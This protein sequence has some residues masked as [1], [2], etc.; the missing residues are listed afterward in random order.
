M[1]TGGTATAARFELR[2]GE[3]WRDPFP[4]YAAL[5][6]HDPVHHVDRGDYWVLTRFADVFRAARD[7]A[8]YSSADGLTVAYGDLVAAGIDEARPLVMLDPPDH[9]GFRRLVGRGFT[10]RRVAE[11][12]P[13]VRA[14]A[15]ERI[16]RLVAE[17]AGG[18]PADLVE[19]LAKPLPSFVVA[20]YLGV[21]E[22]D[23]GRFDRWT[24]AIVSANATGTVDATSDA[25]GELLGYFADLVERR[26]ADPGDDTVSRLV[27]A[28]DLDERT[29]GAEVPLLRILGFAFT[30]VAGGNDTATGLIA[31][32]AELLARR[33]DQRRRLLDDP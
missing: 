9:T 14:F 11:I 5:R 22:A 28:A 2:S 26:R 31:G 17:T 1:T 12:E 15:A 8:T 4:M 25:V 16:D 33:P 29:G 10:P 13:A 18:E 27:H 3:S 24:E 7:T 6:D 23:R 21:P 32:G 20:H 30:M 19:A